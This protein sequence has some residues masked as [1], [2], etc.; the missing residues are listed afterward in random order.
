MAKAQP[1]PV[2][3][4]TPIFAT[5]TPR[6]AAPSIANGVGDGDGVGD[7]VGDGAGVGDGVGMLPQWAPNVASINRNGYG[8]TGHQT[9]LQK[10][11]YVQLA[12]RHH[13]LVCRLGALLDTCAASVNVAC[14]CL[15]ST[16]P[17][18]A[19]NVKAVPPLV[20]PKQAQP[21]GG[22]PTTGLKM[23]NTTYNAWSSCGSSALLN[24]VLAARAPVQVLGFA[25]LC[26]RAYTHNKLTATQQKR[27]SGPTPPTGPRRWSAPTPTV[28]PNAYTHN[29]VTAAQQ[30]WWSGPTPPTGPIRWSAPTPTV[31]PTAL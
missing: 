31:R 4:H 12:G 14:F 7:G 1:A 24:R 9:V 13:Q 17:W 23:P 22:P 21:P 30:P 16:T 5:P 6:F 2:L 28:R 15:A 3:P 18:C 19:A 26:P 11:C 10:L 25:A 29:K 20:L 8:T 27:W